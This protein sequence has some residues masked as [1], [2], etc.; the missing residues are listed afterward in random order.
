MSDEEERMS[1]SGEES[2]QEDEE[3]EQGEEGEEGEEMEEEPAP[4]PKGPKL[5]PGAVGFGMMIPAPGSVALRKVERPAEKAQPAPTDVKETEFGRLELKKTPGPA[6]NK[7][8]PASGE[9]QPEFAKVKLRKTNTDVS[10]EITASS[11]TTATHNNNNNAYTPPFSLV[12]TPKN[13]IN[14]SL[15]ASSD[16]LVVEPLMYWE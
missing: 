15:R 14:V 4:V 6:S 3:V 11:E 2:E 13:N 10:Q 5:P 1:T 16:M 8:P 9:A 7:P 12:K